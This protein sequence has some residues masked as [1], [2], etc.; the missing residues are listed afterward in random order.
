MIMEEW[1]KH[2]GMFTSLFL[3]FKGGLSIKSTL[4]LSTCVLLIIWPKSWLKHDK[5]FNFK[6]FVW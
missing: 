3:G 6:Q 2:F 4:V 1:Q 5:Y